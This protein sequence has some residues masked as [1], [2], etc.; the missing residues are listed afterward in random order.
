MTLA[1][2]V[3]LVQDEYGSRNQ[4]DERTVL[5]YL[6]N[7][8]EM[9]YDRDDTAFVYRDHH[10]LPDPDPHFVYP[11]PGSGDGDEPACR[12]IVGLTTLNNAQLLNAWYN[13]EPGVRGRY[14]PIQLQPAMRT[15][16]LMQPLPPGDAYRLFYYIRPRAFRG[17]QDDERVLIPEE[18]HHSL[19]VQ[20]AGQLARYHLQGEAVHRDQLARLFQPFW[21]SMVSA[22][23]QQNRAGSYSMGQPGF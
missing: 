19:L 21:D 6:S 18:F 9:A 14:I 4:L 1:E 2:M 10:F 11:Y 16:T 20:G 22:M 15:F 13:A 23:S 3:Y 5:L 17:V 7:I 12:K 8:Q